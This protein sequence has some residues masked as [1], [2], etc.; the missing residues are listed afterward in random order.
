MIKVVRHTNVFIL[1]GPCRCTCIRCMEY[2][3]LETSTHT[4]LS[5]VMFHFPPRWKTLLR[6][7]L[8]QWREWRLRPGTTRANQR[9][10][11]NS[12]TSLVIR[13]ITP[14]AFNFAHTPFPSFV[15][16]SIGF[17]PFLFHPCGQDLRSTNGSYIIDAETGEKTRLAPKKATMLPEAGC[18]IQLGGAAC[19]V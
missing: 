11:K 1:A 14:H 13:G 15:L 8:E 12:K 18:R 16:W 19:K 17:G 9:W 3:L 6:S 4:M 10:R 2:S 5:V 7:L